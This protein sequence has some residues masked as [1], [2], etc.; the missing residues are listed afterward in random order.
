MKK[1]AFTLV[2]TFSFLSLAVLPNNASATNLVNANGSILGQVLLSP[3]C[4]VERNPP[5]PAC[6][7]KPYK[8][9]LNIWSTRT[10][11][12]YKPVKT[13]IVGVFKLSL[14]PGPY[15]IQVQKN[16]NG[17]AFPR[18]SKISFSV[19]AHK[20]LKLIVKCDTGIR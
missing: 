3:T 12:V 5:D 19:V 20:T 18:C 4:T 8:T 7:P 13:N 14:A 2:I 17:S 9:S 6:A 15:V 11:I 10:G 1:I 16:A